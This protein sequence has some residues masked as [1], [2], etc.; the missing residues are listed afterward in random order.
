MLRRH[1]LTRKTPM[2]RGKSIKRK[3]A[4][5]HRE[6]DTPSA[7]DAWKAEHLSCAACWVPTWKVWGGLQR[8]HIWNAARRAC[9]DCVFNSLMLCQSC[10]DRLGHGRDN[11]GVC[12]YLKRESDIEN[13]KPE[14]MQERLKRFGTETLPE[15]P[16]ALPAWIT[17]LRKG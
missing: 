9:M 12:L 8:H 5:R 17:D 15:L 11:R 10:H 13:Y 7:I 3:P 4:K 16:A 6:S 2:P 14:L 1:P